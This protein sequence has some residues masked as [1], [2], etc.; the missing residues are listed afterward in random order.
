MG[1]EYMSGERSLDVAIATEIARLRQDVTR[2][3]K[4]TASLREQLEEM[5]KE[6]RDFATMAVEAQEQ[7]VAAPV[8]VAVSGARP[9]TDERGAVELFP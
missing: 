4:E 9:A 7:N 6:N 1:E 2:L 3:E 8:R 5:Q